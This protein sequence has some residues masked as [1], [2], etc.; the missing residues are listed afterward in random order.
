MSRIL[1]LYGS[2]F[3]IS[4]LS[5]VCECFAHVQ[6]HIALRSALFFEDGNVKLCPSAGLGLYI[7][8]YIM[9]E[10]PSTQR[11]NVRRRHYNSAT[12]L[13]AHR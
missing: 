10:S 8:S 7:A 12:S 11:R 6:C 13:Q 5:D 9:Y 4:N 2:G 3:S 1:E